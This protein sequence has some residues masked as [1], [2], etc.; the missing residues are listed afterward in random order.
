M[1]NVVG[2]NELCRHLDTNREG[3]HRMVE[4]GVIVRL[5]DGRYDQDEAR[6]AYLRHL[7]ERKSVDSPERARFE[8]ARAAREEMKAKK[9]A[10][11]LCYTREFEEAWTAVTGYMVA[12]IVAIPARCTRDVALRAVI[13][14]QLDAWRTDVADYFK[15]K[16]EELEGKAA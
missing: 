9:L 16:A 4:Q 6:V 12:G 3:I 2:I 11:E 15:R 5:P 1:G 7:R 13:E 10:G 8:A 14:K